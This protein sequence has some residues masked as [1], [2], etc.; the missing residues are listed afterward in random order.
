MTLA[1]GDVSTGSHALWQKMFEYHEDDLRQK[2]GFFITKREMMEQK[3]QATL[4]EVMRMTEAKAKM[5]KELCDANAEP[6][7]DATALVERRKEI[8]ARLEDIRSI[9]E[10][11]R[12]LVEAPAHGVEEADLWL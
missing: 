7:R 4:Q 10:E 1:V 3:V 5:E 12:R 6:H 8:H 11:S 2:G 9:V